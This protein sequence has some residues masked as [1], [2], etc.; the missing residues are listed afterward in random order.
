MS[1]FTQRR[2]AKP[3]FPPG[4]DADILRS[5]LDWEQFRL[6][7][8]AEKARL[9]DPAKADMLLDWDLVTKTL[10]HIRNLTSDT[11][12][13]KERYNLVLVDDHPLDYD[14]SQAVEENSTQQK[15]SA[16]RFKRLFGSSDRF[17]ST[18]AA[19]VIQSKT[20]KTKK[21][22]W[23]VL[24]QKNLQLLTNDVAHFVGRLHDTLDSSIQTDM[25]RTLQMLLQD[26]TNR[27]SNVPDLEYLKEIATEMKRELVSVSEEADES[28]EERIERQ[29]RNLLF[30]AIANDNVKEVTELLDKGVDPNA[31]DRVGWSTLI[32]AAER[33]HIPMIQL[34]L[35]RGANPLKG[36]IG[37]RL[38]IHFA[39]EEGRTD[40][41]RL[42]LQQPKVDPNARDTYGKAPIFYAANNGHEA[43]V[44]LLLEQKDIDPNPLT[45]DGF[46]P[47]AQS[48]FGD[49]VSIVELL[50]GRSDVNPNGA[51][52]SFNQ[53]PLWMAAS[54]KEGELVRIFLSR[55]DLDLDAAS[56]YGETALGRCARQGYEAS[57]K[58][59]I[60]AGANVNKPNEDGR[61]PLSNAAVE[62]KEKTLEIL[63]SHPGIEM[64]LTDTEGQTALHC[65]NERDQTKCIKMLL[66]HTPPAANDIP[67][68]EGNTALHLAAAKGN[69]IAAKMLL[70]AGAARGVEGNKAGINMQNKQG[71]TPLALASVGGSERHE[72]V[73]RLLL[74]NG[75]DAEL[76]DED[77]ETPFEKARD[78]HLDTV[79]NVF[80]EVLKF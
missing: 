54:H 22:R 28:V 72:A 44:K 36:T 6:E 51:N 30:Y 27:Y 43:I 78:R 35:D 32:K 17:Q 48:I 3:P 58:M 19:K 41:L 45:H 68:K 69:K 66:A 13:L 70:K 76:S 61:T 9:Y 7:Q 55:K 47:L 1:K 15:S 49:H 14:E 74:E 40:A 26:A 64:D 34:L 63:L 79:V 20:S 56:R 46:S 60:E 8:W 77:Q 33:G 50:L 18:A 5:R 65:A 42:F 2:H 75:A 59:L 39:A 11:A 31:Q 4:R 38:P 24:D 21:L 53:T 71:N 73:V 57:L 16:S 37:Y 23:A 62:G 80:K 10:E 67:D 12:M 25:H 29:F 52:K